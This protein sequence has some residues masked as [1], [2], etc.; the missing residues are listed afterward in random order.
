MKGISVIIPT[1]NRG[2][3]LR[4]ALGSVVAQTL[5]CDEIIVIDDGSSD[6]TA[7]ELEGFGQNCP[8]PLRYFY[9]T[10]RGPAAARNTGIH[11]ARYS[12]L[13]FLD[14]DDHWHPKKIARQYSA[15][16]AHP[17][18]L[19]SHTQER[20]LR[21]GQ[22]LNQKKIHR[23]GQGDIF[24]QCLRLCAVGMSTV[25]VKKEFFDEIGTFTVTLRCCE[26][27]DLW[28][29]G[30]QRYPFLLIEQALT[31]K[32]GGRP[33]QVSVQFRVGMDRLR[34]ASII[35]LLL[36]RCLLPQQ[37]IWALEELVRKCHVYGSGCVKH[38]HTRRGLRY[39]ALGQ[40]A[41]GLLDQYPVFTFDRHEGLSRF[42][43]ASL[44]T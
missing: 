43:T 14:S 13:A 23:P 33:D 36:A 35:D 29:R 24:R 15:M 9:Q 1:Y 22:H 10:N 4:R 20:W 19:I 30:S 3:L 2:S 11:E 34:I 44:I 26:D 12:Y 41:R 7:H 21:R 27:Y 16:E 42:S 8:V 32:E 28:L 17:D 18:V 40:W 37:G 39:L 6:S 38:G 25:M 31:I 5:A